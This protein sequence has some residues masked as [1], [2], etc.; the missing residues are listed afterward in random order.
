MKSEQISDALNLLD[1]D[2]IK[3]TELVRDRAAENPRRTGNGWRVW[4]TVAACLCLLLIGSLFLEHFL[5]SP[6]TNPDNTES[7]QNETDGSTAAPEL[8]MLT[9]SLEDFGSAGS[10]FE[11][12]LHQNIAERIA[13]NPW[14]PEKTPD[15]MPV[16][17]NTKYTENSIACGWDEKEMRAQLDFIETALNLEVLESKFTE[18]GHHQEATLT[19]TLSH[20]I[21][22][23]IK[24]DGSIYLDFCDSSYGLPPASKIGKYFAA[25]ATAAEAE[26][27]LGYLIDRFSDLVNVSQPGK[28]L[29]GDYNIYGEY[30]REYRIYDSSGDMVSD[31]LNYSYH[32]L[33][34][35]VDT[36]A[37]DGSLWG[38][39]LINELACAEKIG[40]YPIISAEEARQLLLNGSYI[41]SVPYAFPG[42]EYIATVELVYRR[43]NR[44]ETLIPYYRFYVELPDAEFS[45]E[46][47]ELLAEKNIK[48]YGAYYVPAVEAEYIT[49]MP[50][51]EG[52]FN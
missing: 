14:D 13:Y 52:S 28:V 30:R 39:W 47:K 18:A 16:F 11:G 41:T 24:A 31:I 49:N 5:E 38:I 44:N 2:I 12:I 15:T 6:I 21:F 50:I 7:Q 32:Y 4:G 8:P 25:D 40:D 27:G 43:S 10:G 22:V 17:Q 3:E 46:T 48:D 37:C 20:D 23:S 34:F 51:Y 42:E 36:D 26:M 33:H 45:N 9:L 1:D 29:Y 35:A 19:A